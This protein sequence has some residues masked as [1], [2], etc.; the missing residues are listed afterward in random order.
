MMVE[1]ESNVFVL[2]YNENFIADAMEIHGDICKKNG[3]CWYG[4]AGKRP[5]LNKLKNFI[6]TGIPMIFYNKNKTYL[7]NLIDVSFDNPKD[8]YPEYYDNSMWRP[9]TWFLISELM[10]VDNS[11]INE[12]IVLSTEKKMSETINSSMTSFYFTQTKNNI[13]LEGENNA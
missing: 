5:D 3:N 9:N 13:V 1:A 4:K 10:K 7:C 12:L 8:G 2:R 11:V 6:G